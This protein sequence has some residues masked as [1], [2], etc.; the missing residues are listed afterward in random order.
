MT[1][2]VFSKNPIVNQVIFEV[3]V[4]VVENVLDTVTE[5]VVIILEL[6]NFHEP[7]TFCDVNVLEVGIKPVE[8]DVVKDEI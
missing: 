7:V 3:T 8:K 6:A 1:K 5:N 2:H 4:E